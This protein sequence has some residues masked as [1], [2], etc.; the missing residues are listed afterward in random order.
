MINNVS[1]AINTPA[2]IWTSEEKFAVVLE[3]ATLNEAELSDCILI[4]VSSAG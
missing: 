1:K 3:S 2:E 4:W